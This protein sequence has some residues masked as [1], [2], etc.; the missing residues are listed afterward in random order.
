[1]RF[2]RWFDGPETS[3]AG[4]QAGL[5]MIYLLPPD[6]PVF[7]FSEHG[8]EPIRLS[9]RGTLHQ[10]AHGLDLASVCRAAA[11]A[12]GGEG[13]GH[14]VASGATIPA[15]RRDAFLQNADRLLGEQAH[16]SPG[17]FA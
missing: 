3:L 8:D 6:R 10:V 16:G 17:G 7:A 2:L 9:A 12:V 13:G 11:H 4:T 14:R 5:A 1:M 15:G